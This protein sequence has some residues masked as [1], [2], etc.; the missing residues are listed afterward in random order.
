MDFV[1]VVVVVGALGWRAGSERLMAGSAI[2]VC[3]GLACRSGV[4]AAGVAW[5]TLAPKS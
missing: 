5:C 2:V 4:A 3:S 1:A